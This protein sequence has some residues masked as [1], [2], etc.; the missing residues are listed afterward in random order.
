[1]AAHRLAAADDN[2]PL[3]ELMADARL[4]PPP[5]PFRD[6][7]ARGRALI[8]ELKRRSP[9]KGE[10]APDLVPGALAKA[11]EAGGAVCLSVLTDAAFFG[12]LP[13]DLNE[14]RSACELPVLR[15]DFT[16]SERDVCDA[17][18]MGADAVL[19]IVA[20]LSD[21]EL[22]RFGA[23]ARELGLAV[24]VEVHTE[25]ELARSIGAGADL[26][27][28]NQRDLASFAVDDRLASRL[29]DQ[30]PG[31]V[32]TVA[33]SGIRDGR[34]AARLF[35]AGYDALLVGESLVTSPDPTATVRELLRGA[36]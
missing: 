1:V 27:G 28:V 7:L 6:T 2:R 31:G 26:I 18:I 3:D 4:H 17:R 36:S 35:A 21:D 24:L 22:S 9:S 32:V 11:Y 30:M 20:A 16:V 25:H 10:L 14:A 15:K 8:G 13:T 19:L 29:R 12:A 34:D 33:E 5:R 23:V